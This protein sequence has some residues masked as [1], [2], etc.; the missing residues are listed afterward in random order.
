MGLLGRLF[1]AVQLADS[2]LAEPL[3]GTY[4]LQPGWFDLLAALRRAGAPYES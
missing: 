4:G 1:R 3:A 2:A